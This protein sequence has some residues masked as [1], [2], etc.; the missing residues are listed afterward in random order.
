MTLAYFTVLLTKFKVH[1]QHHCTD[2]QC[3]HVVLK[4]VWPLLIGPKAL[5][6]PFDRLCIFC[7]A[8]RAIEEVGI[9]NQSIVILDILLQPATGVSVAESEKV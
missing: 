9:L 4:G 6:S 8:L 1:L 7:V 2:D 5:G 3:S